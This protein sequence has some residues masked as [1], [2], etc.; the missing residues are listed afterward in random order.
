M[1]KCPVCGG[2]VIELTCGEH[3]YFG[4]FY[5]GVKHH[6]GYMCVSCKEVFKK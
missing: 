6:I 5:G 4:D 3:G 2:N 1:N